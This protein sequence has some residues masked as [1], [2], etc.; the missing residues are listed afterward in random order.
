MDWIELG[1]VNAHY[2]INC[3]QQTPC[4]KANGL[5]PG[6]KLFIVLE[7]TKLHCLYYNSSPIYHFLNVLFQLHVSKM[8]KIKYYVFIL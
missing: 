8:L 6:Q 5:W 1:R 2:L 3:L 4:T 7:T